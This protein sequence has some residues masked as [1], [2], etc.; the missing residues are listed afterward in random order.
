MFNFILR[1]ILALPLVM[2]A[3]TVL[4]VG[5]LQF[6][7]PAERAVAFIN[8][9]NQ[10]RNLERI[11]K[12]KG[13]DQPFHVQYWSWLKGAVKGD[14]GFSKASG[15]TVVQTMRERFPATLEL[16][17]YAIIPV[18]GF[19]VW[20]GTIAGLRKNQ[21]PDQ[22]ARIISVIG[23]SLPTFVL[24][25]LLLVVFYGFWGILPGFGRL[26]TENDLAL[27]I[28][29]IPQRTGLL[30][31]DALLAGRF[32][33]FVD[34]LKHLI[35]PVVTLVVVSSATILKVMRS[36]IIEVLRSDYVRTARAKGLPDRVV[37]L[38]HAR[39]NALLPIITLGGF[40]TIGLLG[41]VLFTE[42]IFAYPGIG[43]WAADAA[44]KFDVPAV[45]GFALLSAVIVVVVSTAVDIL[46][47]LVDP[48]VRFD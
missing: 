19:G 30:T 38:K 22:L 26:S 9:E 48:R 47:G 28:D 24:G 1:R 8:N 37:N 11:I 3:V 20:F 17:L 29:P 31:V 34:A 40:T 42:T 13:L 27:L 4:I 18:I 39:R 16:S 44:G 14:L 6:L 35:L 36:N 33:I 45:M 10:M 21:L 41:G 32:N 7:T 43:S 5:L 2:L 46:Y 12:E 15:K 25:I 23:F